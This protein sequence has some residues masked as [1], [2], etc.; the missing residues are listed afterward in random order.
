VTP[1]RDELLDRAAAL[2]PLLERNAAQTEADR[3]LV[4]ESL[5]AVREAGLLRIVN[6]KRFGGYETDI[7][8]M[9]D[10]SATLATGCGSTGWVVNLINVC[11]WLVGLYP[12]QTQEEVWGS[13]PDTR[14]AG[15]LAPTATTRRVDGGLVVSG[16]WPWLSG[17]LHAQWGMG[18]VPVVDESGDMVDVGLAL[19]PMHEL[20]V[21]DTWFVVG[22]RGTGSNTIVA[23]D[24]LVPDHRI[25]PM[26]RAIEGEYPTE[27]KDEVLYRS[28]FIPVLALILV[29]PLLGLARAALHYVVEK[30]PRRAIT[31]TSYERQTDSVAFQMAIAEAAAKVDTAHLHAYRAAADIDDAARAGTYPDLPARARVR[32]DAGWAARQ[33]R[34]AVDLLISAHGASAFAEASPLQRIWR[35]LNTA[36]RHA[37]V[38]PSVNEEIYGK[39][40]LGVQ[41]QI[42]DLI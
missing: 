15:A 32:M 42:T 24:I 23:D 20:S 28:A 13:D 7:R 16:R 19:M 17:S 41:P 27:F 38:N 12:R 3:R 8:T 5:E 25:L 35:D 21:E 30:A 29:G 1:T 34:E 14:V 2:R 9:L 36:S 18:G 26:P 11:S 10:V 31:Y 39:A 40:L 33:A 22:M 4:D 37:V 6:P